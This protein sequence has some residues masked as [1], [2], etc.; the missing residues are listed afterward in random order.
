MEQPLVSV[1][2][3]VYN[4]EQYIREC[5]D[6]VMAQ[7]YRNIEVVVADNASTDETLAIVRSYPSVRVIERKSNS[8]M[9]STTRNLAAQAAQG[10]YIAF[11][12]SDDAWHP[13]KLARQV[14]FMERHSDIALCHSYVRLMDEHSSVYGIRHEGRLPPTGNYFMPLLDHCWVTISSTLIRRSLYEE[15]GPFTEALPYGRS[16]EDYEFF[17]KAART[18]SFGLIDEPLVNYRKSRHSITA[19]DWQS[20]PRPISFMRELVRRQ[21]IW[22]GFVTPSE[23]RQRVADACRENA[24]YWR[25][26]RN[27]MR[28]LWAVGQA[29]RV[30]PLGASAWSELLRTLYRLCLAAR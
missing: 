3:G 20:T 4:R 30:S 15:V 18:H 23:M 26:Q 14:E 29:L 2:I 24:I 12:D 19:S 6:S 5:L 22:T 11:L 17:L 9:C 7:T 21:D 16:G 28:S 1:C 13:T 25:S 27:P 8:G 10:D